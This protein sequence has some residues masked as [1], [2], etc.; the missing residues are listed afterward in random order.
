MAEDRQ[1]YGQ[2]VDDAIQQEHFGGVDPGAAGWLGAPAADPLKSTI[3]GLRIIEQHLVPIERRQLAAVAILRAEGGVLAEM[4]NFFMDHHHL[5]GGAGPLVEA[6]GVASVIKSFRG[7]GG[8]M[9]GGQ[10]K[11]G[12]GGMGGGGRR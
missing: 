7:F 1:N 2:A 6:L 11:P 10:G 3:E 5:Q 9:F 8:T 4:A 12:G